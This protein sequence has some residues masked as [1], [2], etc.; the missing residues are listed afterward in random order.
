MH[1][2]KNFLL[3]FLFSSFL[4][5]CSGTTDPS[6][7]G[8]FSYNPTAYEKRLEQ[9]ENYLADAQAR[10]ESE[11]VRAFALEN[12]VMDKSRRVSQQQQQLISLRSSI[13]HER[14]RLATAAANSGNPQYQKL[15]QR[16]AD[17]ES[18]AQSAV[19]EQ[20]IEKRRA[21]L[22]QLRNE[23]A[24]LQQDVEALNKE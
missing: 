10:Q 15:Q 9:R 17:M 24:N 22:N 11:Q 5:A 13:A 12:E 16:A 23:Y 20:N 1:H 8:L 19:N 18:Q 3:I 6:K 2:K 21:Y 7:G 14:Q 4:V